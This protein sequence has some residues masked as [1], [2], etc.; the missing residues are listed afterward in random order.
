LLIQ[1]DYIFD[2]YV[3]NAITYGR[4]FLYF[5]DQIQSIH[6]AMMDPIC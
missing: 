4:L 1:V 5:L 2:S 6:H 3:R